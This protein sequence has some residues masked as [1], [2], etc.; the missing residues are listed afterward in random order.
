MR[1]NRKLIIVLV[2]IASGAMVIW[3]QLSHSAR[4]YI[5][6]FPSKAFRYFNGNIA[7]TYANTNKELPPLPDSLR[8][9]D[10]LLIAW[11]SKYRM[12][13]YYSGK[14]QKTYII[15]LGQEPIGHKQQQGDNRTPEGNYRIIQKTVGPFTGGGSS[16]WLGTR[17]MRLNYPNNSD[18]K[19]GLDKKLIS[20]DEYN[21]IVAA[22]KSGKEPPKNTKLGG[23][24][25]IHGW[26]GRWPGNDE[27]DIT[28][29]CIS[30][31]NDQ[32]EDLYDRVGLQTRIVICK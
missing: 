18:A 17:W 5:A 1:K 27:Q 8:D 6:G 22:N 9:V 3:P 19:A 29:G 12:Q 24:I 21:R 2:L 7:G 30:M 25:G 26:N 13:L 15:G 23:G 11:K 14:L 31:Q 32:V 10:T 20:K 28:W 16:A 4:N